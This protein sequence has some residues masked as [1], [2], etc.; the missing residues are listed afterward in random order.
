MRIS[1]KGFALNWKELALIVLG[2]GAGGFLLTWSGVITVAA[3]SGHWSITEW[4]LHWAMR[5]SVRTHALGI[6]APPLDDPVLVHQG[7]G[8][9]ASGCAPCHGAPGEPRSRIAQEMTPHPPYLPPEISQWEPNQ[10]FW[11]VMHGIKLTGMP[12]W[13]AQSRHDEVWSMV[14]FL[15]KLP[16]MKPKEYLDLALGPT[17][18]RTDAGEQLASLSE[19]LR[20]VV[21]ECARCHGRDGTGRVIRA[22]P[23][24]TGQNE[25]YLFASL[26][27][28]AQGS[29][30]SG[31]MQ[32][33]ASGLE[34]KTLRALAKHYAA[35]QAAML[36]VEQAQ[37]FDPR[38]L[39]EG[40]E[41]AERGVPDDAIPPCTACHGPK[42]GP[43]HSVYP[44]LAGQHADY[45]A[46]Q[47]ELFQ[48]SARGGT[49]FAPIMHMVATRLSEAQIRAV[50]AYYASLQGSAVALASSGL[51]R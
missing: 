7:G 25:A 47:L 44:E 31:I 38:L 24:L 26:K 51:R 48:Q 27:A 14:A 18:D 19:P 40:K 3:S 35:A 6:N 15:N 21:S 29:R 4:F 12:A 20:E 42:Q 28:F 23:V 50:T 43:R 11:I 2:L 17:A 36:M 5:S 39:R 9:Y 37:P 32:P 1:W 41:I 33:A 22:F 46:Q 30:H 49:P 16:E 10:L 8:H 13:V 34:E 45:L